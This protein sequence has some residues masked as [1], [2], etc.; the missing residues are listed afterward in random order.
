MDT[1]TK[2][3]TAAEVRSFL[4][5]KGITAKLKIRWQNNP[6]GGDGKFIVTL[7]EIPPGSCL[8]CSSGSKEPKH[9]YSADE[10]RTAKIMNDMLD[11]LRGTNTIVG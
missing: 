6:F 1:A 8:I 5:Q 7:A 11:I 3:S 4:K 2:F 9:F 10:G